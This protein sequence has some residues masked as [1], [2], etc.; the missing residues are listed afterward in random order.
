[1]NPEIA[2]PVPKKVSRRL[3]GLV[4]SDIRRMTREADRLGAINLGQGICDMPTPL[5]VA[6]GAVAAIEARKATY[7]PFEGI[8]PLREGIA[9]QLAAEGMNV[10]PAKGL[11][12]TVGST[13]ALASTLVALLDPGDE[14]ILFE[15]F[16]GYHRSQIEVLGLTHRACP[17]EPGTWKFDAAA[18]E[19]AI[20]PSTRAVIVN[21][22]ANPSGHVFGEADLAAIAAICVRHGL[23][24]ITDEIYERI[25][26]DG[27]RHLRLA[28]FPG[29]ADRTVTI[30]GFSK[31]FSITG[32]RIG[33]AAAEPELA[34]R[35]G[36]ASDVL[37][38]CA[39]TPLQWGVA[40]GIE[41]LP[42]SYYA[43]LARGYQRKRDVVVDALREAGMPADPPE[44]AYYILADVTRLGFASA[45]EAAKSLLEEG[46]VASVPG[47]S[48][49]EGSRGERFL[50]F[51]FAKDDDAID[52]AARRIA[53]WGKRIR[54]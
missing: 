24:A 13:G 46:L 9:K 17:L 8:A 27:R 2:P 20:G 44:G 37:S 43:D 33:W 31:T 16:Y 23:L 36:L 45:A 54:G 28:T 18:F 53:A 15:P 14:V 40:K 42:E 49:F 11:V 35:I 26:F 19:A 48:F 6:G 12:V 3:A 22:P 52:E 30:S 1:M 21:T 38:V 29:M 51:C 5:P 41:E 32:W 34:L 25:L 39:P 7:S 10:D 50:R 47:T 4:Q